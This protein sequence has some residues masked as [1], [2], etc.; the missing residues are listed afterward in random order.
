[1]I[2]EERVK[3]IENRL[4][5]IEQED[6]LDSLI[7][8]GVKEAPGA[9]EKSCINSITSYK[10]GVQVIVSELTKVYRFALPA[11]PP[12][13]HMIASVLAQFSSKYVARKLFAAKSKLAKSYIFVSESLTKKRREM[14]QLARVRL[15]NQNVWSDHGRNFARSGTA[16][17]PRQLWSL[18]DI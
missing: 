13:P 1:M 17:R 9:D 10:M 5:K 3:K 14:L 4:D 2:L 12:R 16:T 11:N 7:F 6:R 8:S 15:G 18:D